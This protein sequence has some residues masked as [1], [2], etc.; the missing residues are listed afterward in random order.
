MVELKA[1]TPL[2]G[3]LPLRIGGISLDEVNPGVMTSLAPFCG[4]GEALSAALLEAHGMAAPAPNRVSEQGDARAI[5]FGREMILLSGPEPVPRLARH[6]ALTDQSDAWAVARLEG[7]GAADVLARL[8]PLDLRCQVFAPGHTARSLVQ[9]MQASITRLEADAFQIMV[10]RAFGRT[11]VH[12]LTVA[13]E[14][15]A[16]R[17][18]S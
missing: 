10:F 15:V 16:A 13:M 1:R 4:Q 9:H 6:A 7:R 18:S 17:A 5:W 2:Q 8:C 3:L 11:L 12:E 14:G